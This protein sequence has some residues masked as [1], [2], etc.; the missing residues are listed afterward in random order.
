MSLPILGVQVIEMI[1]QETS[2]IMIIV[3]TVR[4]V[5]NMR[6]AMIIM[7]MV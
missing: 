7:T 1:P 2:A 4:I 6:I 5:D 3:M